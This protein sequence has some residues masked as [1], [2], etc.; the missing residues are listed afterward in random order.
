MSEKQKINILWFT[1]NLRIRD[2]ESLLK[3]QQESL[4]FL[5]LYV[6]DSEFF[7]QK[8]SGF[9]KIGKFR[10]RFLLETVLD[11]E[12]NL[13]EIGVP[14]VKKIGKTAEIFQK[15]AEH[16]DIETIFCQ[17]EWTRDE[18]ILQQK[19]TKVL[20]TT[21][22]S[23]SYSQ[24]L[25]QPDFIDSLI[26]KI[27]IQFTTFRQ[28]VEKNFTIRE[29]FKSDKTEK[30]QS[31]ESKIKSDDI[32]LKMLGFEDFEI[33]PSS[34]F[35][36]FGGETVAL[37][38]LNAY[39]SETKNLSTYKETR[40][41]MTGLDYSSKFSAW[42]A[43]GSLSPVSVYHEIK[44]YEAEFGSNESTYWLVFELLW[45][46]FFKYVSREHQDKTF[47]LKGILGKEYPFKHDENVIQDWIQGKTNSDFIN[48]NMLE[49]KQTGWMSNRGR[50][51]VASYFCKILNQ[52]WRIGAHYFEEMLID[53]DVHSNYGN[54]MYLAGVG[55]DPRSRTFNPETGRTI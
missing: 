28:K 49:I 3:I 25:L 45:R 47:R 30:K 18:N 9:K 39:F 42:L 40:N 37:K 32:N 27:P 43:N 29:E 52:D 55:N 31:F 36:F 46:E 44:K 23:K 2:N 13:N 54:W 11:L 26:E 1:N 6:F 51:N 4:P 50:Q 5:A 7:Q 16:F 41:G 17:E 38:R 19:V 8:Q 35:P 15:I 12:K 33:H 34:A 14:F 24:L 21:V 10:A 20:P 22:W 48:A 53:Y